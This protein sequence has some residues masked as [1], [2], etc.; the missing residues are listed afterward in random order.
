MAEEPFKYVRIEAADV[1]RE[2]G[3]VVTRA[4]FLADPSRLVW[5]DGVQPEWIVE[6]YRADEQFR[7]NI[8]Y[9]L[10]RS[11][12]KRA[13]FSLASGWLQILGLAL[14]PDEVAALYGA[15]RDESARLELEWRPEFEAAFP[16]AVG[17]LPPVSR[18]G[19]RNY[20]EYVLFDA[21]ASSNAAGVRQ[22]LTALRGAG[23]SFASLSRFSPESLEMGGPIWWE[24]GNDPDEGL[25]LLQVAEKVASAEVRQLVREAAEG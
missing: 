17:R 25:T 20:W 3:A 10:S 16:Q 7:D 21:I 18:E 19:A 14:S 6:A 11:V 9:A 5:Q 2:P 12:S 24:A 8:L 4:A 23:I 15:I 22:A 13:D 1:L